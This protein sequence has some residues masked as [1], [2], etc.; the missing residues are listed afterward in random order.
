[1]KK[2]IYLLLVCSLSS[3]L[4]SNVKRVRI[5]DAQGNPVK[6]NKIVP[7]FNEEQMK[8]QKQAFDSSKKNN[9]SANAGVNVDTNNIKFVNKNSGIMQ[10]INDP[11][12]IS[13]ENNLPDD[14]VFA[15]RIT[16]F[17]YVENEQKILPN[18]ENGTPSVGVYNKDDKSVVKGKNSVHRVLTHNSIKNNVVEDNTTNSNTKT[19]SKTRKTTK[20]DNNKSGGYFI[21]IGVFNEKSNAESSYSKYS[22][23]SNGV[24]SDYSSKGKIKYKVSLGPYNDKKIAEKDLE[25]VIKMGHYD[26]YITEK[27]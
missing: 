24:I 18:G 25:K 17:N 7:E 14:D 16:N 9:Y 11:N 23:I 2:L 4:Q 15:D 10:Q 19:T 6:I 26:V 22:K 1:M 20:K 27:K 13:V 3:C 21:Q 12:F 5:V 8:K